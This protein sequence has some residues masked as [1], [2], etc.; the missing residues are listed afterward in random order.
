M[1]T[2]LLRSI[3]TMGMAASLTYPST[4]SMSQ[5]YQWS[6]INIQVENL[7]NLYLGEFI[8]GYSYYSFCECNRRT[9]EANSLWKARPRNYAN[10]NQRWIT[11]LSS[12]GNHLH[13]SNQL[14]YKQATDS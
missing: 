9:M 13:G 3:I 14:Y 10:K 11:I 1:V 5:H 6:M 7:Y 4:T 8:L 12:R 2:A